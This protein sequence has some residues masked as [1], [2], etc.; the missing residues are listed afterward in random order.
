MATHYN[1]VGCPYESSR[2]TNN[3]KESERHVI[4]FFARKW[5]I[6]KGKYWGYVTASG[7]E[8]NMQ[9]LMKGRDLLQKKFHG[10]I[11]VLVTS[12]ESHYSVF[13]LAHVLGMKVIRV[14]TQP[15]GEI[16]YQSLDAKLKTIPKQTGVVFNANLGT[17]MKGATDDV[18][19]MYR[20]IRSNN[21]Q[22]SYYMHADGALMGFILPYLCIDVLFRKYI[23]SVSTSG[24]KFLGVPFPCGIFIMDKTIQETLP[25]ASIPYVNTTDNTIL[26]SRNGHSPLFMEHAIHTVGDD[27]FSEDIKTCIDTSQ[28]CTEYMISKGIDAWR[29]QNSITVVFP[30]AVASSKVQEKW[31]IATDG[32]ISHIVVM[33]H[34]TRDVI[35]KFVEDLSTQKALQ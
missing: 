35:V 33:P 25:T 4:D 14:D 6:E 9:G 16:C 27:G 10:T 26:S 11:P 34:V 28:W 15:H 13:K 5:G 18:M 23:H 12:K 1:N 31:Q 8:G 17:T 7:T 2:Y 29:N 22:E 24:H 30:S 20:V 19:K 3:T 32:D 21:M